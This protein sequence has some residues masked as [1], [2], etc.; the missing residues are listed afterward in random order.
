MRKLFF[1]ASIL[2]VWMGGITG[3]K[4]TGSANGSDSLA[5]DSFKYAF[6]DSMLHCNIVADVPQGDDS[7]AVG[8][9]VYVNAQL[10][11]LS[12]V[13]AF[14]ASRSAGYSGDL[15]DGQ[16]LVDFY[17]KLNVDSMRAMQSPDGGAPEFQC[18]YDVAIRLAAQ[19]ERYVTYSVDQ[20]V[21]GGGAH[22]S[23]VSYCVNILKSSG[24]VL[25]ATVDAAQLDAIQPLLL[26]GVTTYINAQGQ[27][28]TE[29]EAL[30]LLFI[31]KGIIPL[32]VHAPYLAADG[33]HFVYQQYE[34]GPYAMGMVSFT[35]PY[36]KVKPYMTAEALQLL[37]TGAADAAK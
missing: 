22:G 24:R 12:S 1:V 9:R 16:A 17:G 11:S 13:H 26:H 3:C 7:L 5:V 27:K 28:V 32:P 36:D 37:E 18:S 29:D 8:V 4:M 31:D 19:N 25:G 14:D 20:Y 35:L 34:I 23:A 10:D 30:K 33:L 21:Y 6:A 2:L 15:T